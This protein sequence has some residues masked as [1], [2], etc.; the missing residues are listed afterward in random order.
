MQELMDRAE[1]EASDVLINRLTD[2]IVDQYVPMMCIDGDI[3]RKPFATLALMFFEQAWAHLDQDDILLVVQENLYCDDGE[4][5]PRNKRKK[6]GCA[7]IVIG[8]I[9]SEN[10]LKLDIKDQLS[11]EK[12]KIESQPS[13]WFLHRHHTGLSIRRVQ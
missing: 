3:C 12:V 5:K 10:I 1:V 4:E 11:R 9:F 2:M 7:A 13:V 6:H 8:K